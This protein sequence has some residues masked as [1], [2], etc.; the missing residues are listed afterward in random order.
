MSFDHGYTKPFS[1]GW[2]AVGPMGEAYRYREWYGCEPGTA[3]KGIQLSPRQ[4]AEGI[5]EREREYEGANNISIDRIADPAIFERSRG[6]SVAQQMEPRDGQPGIY[7]R[8]GDHARIA[9]KMQ[10]HER[11]RFSENGRPLLY[12]FDTCRDFVR[13]IPN[14]PYDPRKAEDVDTAAEDHCYDEGR[15]FFMARPAPIR[16]EARIE[17]KPF[18]PFERR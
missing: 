18:S 3:N 1:V 11:L 4:I 5:V 8:K 15:Y 6:D 9:G 10:Y 14:L 17:P 13:T 16:E 12:V 7:F 2:W